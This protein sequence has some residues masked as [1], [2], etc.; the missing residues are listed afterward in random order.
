MLDSKATRKVWSLPKV[1]FRSGKG[2][3]DSMVERAIREK[4]KQNLFVFVPC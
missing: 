1:S 4:K 3:C 2:R